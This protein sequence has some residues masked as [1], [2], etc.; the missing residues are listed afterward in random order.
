[1]AE[2]ARGNRVHERW[3]RFR[4]SV[5][6][7]LLAAPARKG[8]LA[9][10]ITEL[11][12]RTWHHPISGEPTRFGFSTIERWYYFEGEE[13]SSGRTAPQAARRRRSAAGDQR[14][15]TPGHHRPV[16]RA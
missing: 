10:T 16:R 3:A 2:Q 7:Q 13:G 11:A 14:L 15:G 6:G 1:M 5:I 4:F 8:E 9:S 12:E